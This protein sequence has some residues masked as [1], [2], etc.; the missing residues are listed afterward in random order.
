M[1]DALRRGA[2]GW[3]AKI[4]LFVLVI[5]F[6]IWGVADVFRGYGQGALARIGGVEISTDEFQRTYQLELDSL[7]RQLGRRLSAEQARAFGVDARVLSQLLGAAAIDAH[8]R[9][10]GLALSDETVAKVIKRDPMFRGPDGNFSQLALDGLLRQ[11]G[12]SERGLLTTRRKDEVREQLTTALF[13]GITVPDPLL[14]LLHKFREETRVTQSFTLDP[15]KAVK[16]PEPDEAK[17]KETYEANK[18][19]FVTPEYR[20]LALLPVTLE[21]MKK[22]VP[23]TE[24]EI[25]AAYEQDERRFTIPEKRRIQQIAFKDRNAAAMTAQA[26]AAGQGF[27]EAAKNAGAK[28][29]DIELGLLN[30]TDLIDPKITEAAFAL[31]LNQV[32]DVV[33]GRFTTVLLKVTEIQPGRQRTFDEVKEEVRNRIA[34]ERAAQQMQ[35]LHDQVE[36]NRSA[37]RPLNEI[38]RLLELPF[39]EIA[40]TDRTGKAPD[41]TLV[42]GA[43]AQRIATAAFGATVGVENEALELGDGGSAWFD[44]RSIVPEKQKPFDDVKDEVKAVW[45]DIETRKALSD[46]A[47]KIVERARKG[48]PFEA[49][50]QEVG[51]KIETSKPFKRYGGAPGLPD[52]AVQQAFVVPNGGVAW[53]ASKDGKLR[54][55]VKVIDVTPAPSPEKADLDRLRTDVTRQM[56]RDVLAAYLAALRGRLGVSINEAM[57]R[58]A[59]GADQQQ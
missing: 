24:D 50:A 38:A 37:G 48:E 6:A 49:L 7:A 28:E 8:A 1:L 3:A 40:A 56:E 41:G 23:V 42:L 18:R 34:G 26:I 47:A 21:E 45:I 31:P 44:V 14:A 2:A 54:V 9:E 39:Q 36:D 51:G 55:V 57:F 13:T 5:S 11:A 59:T 17:L 30:K 20:S 53:A 4:L 15:E 10:M 25:K 43:D 33:E 16:L 46:T 58:R 27:V 32:S 12:L 29:S 22:R 52:T 35:K 19:Q